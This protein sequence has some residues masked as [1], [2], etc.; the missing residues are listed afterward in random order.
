MS[1]SEGTESTG[2]ISSQLAHIVPSFDPSKD[3]VQLYQQKVQLVLSMWPTNKILELT[4]RL[5]LNTSGSAFSKL[6]LHQSEI[7]INDEKGVRK[8]IELLGGHWGKTSLEKRYFDAERALYQCHQLQDESHDSFLARADI[9]WTKLKTQN[10]KLEDLQAYVML[11]G[12]MLSSE[13]KKRVILD[14]DSSLEG[15]LTVTRVQEAVRCS[16]VRNLFLSG[17]DGIGEES[18]EEQGV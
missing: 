1:G 14:S 15:T 18:S 9:L 10:L 11:R 8:I 3:D 17:D 6:Q 12:A 5:V 7:C 13:D 16:Q 4:T 2:G